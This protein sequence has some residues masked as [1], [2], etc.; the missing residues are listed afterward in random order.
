GTCQPGLLL[1]RLLDPPRGRLRPLEIG[2]VEVRLVEAGTFDLLD[3]LAKD[4]EDVSGSRAVE[5]EVR[6]KKHRIRAKAAG[7][8]G[9]RR[10]EHAELARLVRS[11]G[12]DSPRPGARDHDGQALQLRPPLQL[13]GDVERVHVDMSNAALHAPEASE[14]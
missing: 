4:G 13:N 3:V 9:G 11:S 10:G 1:N 5:L 14:Q 2:Q 12:D 7:A 8:L 6:R